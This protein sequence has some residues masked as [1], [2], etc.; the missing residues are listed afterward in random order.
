MDQKILNPKEEV[1]NPSTEF[2]ILKDAIERI[3]N[4]IKRI[5]KPPENKVYRNKS[6]SAYLGV[7]IRC[8]QN[9]RDKS[10]I[11]YSQVFGII[12][13]QQKDVTAFLERRRNP[14]RLDN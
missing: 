7:S 11:S 13:Y 4:S 3:E 5:K 10:L 2:E 6:L 12:F 1:T 9:Y 8:L 14:A